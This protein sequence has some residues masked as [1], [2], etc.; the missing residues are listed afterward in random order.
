LCIPPRIAHQLPNA[1]KR[2][3]VND[4]TESPSDLLARLTALAGKRAAASARW[5][6]S[7]QWL[8][9]ELRRIA[10]QLRIHDISVVFE[11]TPDQRLI[12]IA[13]PNRPPE[14]APDVSVN[15]E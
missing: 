14:M 3:Y 5:P 8:S 7:P 1:R 11:R 2:R 13:M 9:I 12:T 4:W 15:G 6:K 10:P